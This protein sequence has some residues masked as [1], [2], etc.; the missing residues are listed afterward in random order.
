MTVADGTNQAE[1]LYLVACDQHGRSREGTPMVAGDR[2]TA[3]KGYPALPWGCGPLHHID[4]K[5]SRWLVVAAEKVD[6]K[7]GSPL[8]FEGRILADGD[9]AVALRYLHENG[10]GGMPYLSRRRRGGAFAV[11]TVGSLGT[12]EADA[13]TI[14]AGGEGT[15]ATLGGGPTLAI[16]RSSQA[17]VGEFARVAA[18]DVVTIKAERFASVVAGH[19]SHVTVGEGSRVVA[20]DGSELQV[21]AGGRAM[22]D[23]GGSLDLGV[24]A[25]GIGRGKT[26]YRGAEGATFVALDVLAGDLVSVKTARV[27]ADGIRPEVWYVMVDGHF[28]PERD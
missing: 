17:T 19:A 6:D 14:A 8:V 16:G 15:T 2:F 9:R 1:V 23:L 4:P 22:I 3:P 18:G 25:V 5:A 13:H 27:G 12:I 28:V 20:G 21:G 24:R 26:R 10:A 7:P 11:L